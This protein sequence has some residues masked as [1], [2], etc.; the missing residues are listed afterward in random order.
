[1]G[2]DCGSFEPIASFVNSGRQ[3]VPTQKMRQAAR[4]DLPGA[5][6]LNLAR[7]KYLGLALALAATASLVACAQTAARNEP[8]PTAVPEPTQTAVP[9]TQTPSPSPTP[10]PSPTA[11]PEPTATVQPTPVVSPTAIPVN[12]TQTYTLSLQIEGISDESIVRGDSIVLRGQTT[13]DAIVSINGVIVP[14]DETG[15][16]EVPLSLE[17]GPN[18]IVVV[19]SD[20]DGDEVSAS[21]LVVSL[22]EE[23]PEGQV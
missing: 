3:A 16:F 7:V 1:M 8:T 10:E 11:T 15:L 9:P 18:R 13:A 6:L 22:P 21:F 23:E 5:V 12:N 20:L 19:A 4:I 14:V 2:E 17:P